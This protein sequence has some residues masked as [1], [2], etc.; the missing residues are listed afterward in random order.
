MSPSPPNSAQLATGFRDKTIAR[1][2][3]QKIH[4]FCS[5]L[6]A[7]FGEYFSRVLPP[8]QSSRSLRSRFGQFSKKKMQGLKEDKRFLNSFQ[9][10]M[11]FPIA[12]EQKH[13]DFHWIL[14]IPQKAL[15]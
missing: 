7:G 13:I 2:P 12:M 5:E 4:G 11:G 14:T 15:F 8:K 10:S 9:T 1:K 3:V 6:A